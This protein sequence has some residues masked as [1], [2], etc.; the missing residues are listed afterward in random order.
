MASAAQ[1]HERAF[2]LGPALA[3]ASGG[4]PTVLLVL[5]MLALRLLYLA[6]WCPYTLIEDEAHYWEWSRQIDWSY[7]SKGPG[8]AWT[9]W[10]TTHALPGLQEFAVRASAPVFHA[11][12][13][14]ALASLASSCFRDRRVGFVTAAVFNL[15]PGFQIAGTLFVIDMPFAACWALAMLAAYHAFFARSGISWIALGI[16]LAIGFMYKYTIVLLIPGLAH[17]L[18]WDRDRLVLPRSWRWLAAGCL[19]IACVGLVPVGIWNAQHG[20]PTIKHLL[21]HLGVKGGDTPVVQG[22]GKGWSYNPMWTIDFLIAQ[23]GISGPILLLA[24][25]ACRPGTWNTPHGELGRR[26]ILWCGAPIV[27]FYLL[28]SLVTE[29]EGNWS[30]AAHLSV[31][32]LAAAMVIQMLDRVSGLAVSQFNPVRFVW[33]LSLILGVVAGVVMLRLDWIDR[34]LAAVGASDGV[35]RIVPMSRLSG[36]D[37]QAGHVSRLLAELPA[38]SFVMAKHYGRASQMAYYLP[39]QPRVYCASAYLDHGRRTQYDV[40]SFTDLANPETERSLLGRDAVVMG[41]TLEDWQPLFA[42]VREIG[43]LDGDRKRGRP[44]FVAMG[45]K[46]LSKAGGGR[47]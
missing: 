27:I 28:V 7:Y 33:H 18:F 8:V 11:I 23:F 1:H 36:A 44:A 21:G 13:T 29:P 40:W 26:F 6:F 10:I 24:L 25:A 46:G 12:T 5:V 34:G 22:A 41:G 19:L 3:W 2:A 15:M 17:T 30:I 35:R 37:V 4:L 32:P 20:W 47:P 43:T 45:Y 14:L 16:A 9:L 31:A 38:N 42:S 39:D